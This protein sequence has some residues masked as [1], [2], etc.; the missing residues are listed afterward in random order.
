[1]A[2]GQMEIISN[3]QVAQSIFEMKVP[4]EEKPQAG[5]FCMLRSPD[6]RVLLP[7]AI[8]VCDWRDGVL[9][10]LYQVVGEGTRGLSRLTPGSLLGMT[11]PV[12]NGFPRAFSGRVALVGG[13]I[14]IAPLLYLARC[15][16]EER[17]SCDAY[18]G[19]RD[20]PFYV[21]CFEP[22]ADKVSIA[23]ETGQAG[24]KG[25]V[26]GLL[27]PAGYEA[28]LCCGPTPMMRAVTS[29]CVEAGTPVYVSLENRMACGIG[30]CLVCTCGGKDGTYRRVCKD[31]PVFRGEAVDFDD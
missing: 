26:T 3:R 19:F 8:S 9:T 30:A 4:L 27:E 20:E 31:G 18:L 5:Q 28:V 1:M 10:F 14:G 22:L 12:G 11:G 6:S 2:Y 21:D 23:T 17:V 13:G 16:R 7:R 24:A 29:L 25:F 15:L